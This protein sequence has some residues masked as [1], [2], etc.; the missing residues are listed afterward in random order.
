QADRIRTP[1]IFFQ[2]LRDA[3]VLP[4]QTEQMV[5]ALDDNGVPVHCVTFADERHGFRQAAHLAQVLEEE[6][7]FYQAWL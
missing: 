2:G 4:S 5:A 7:A 1:V 3:V 6:L